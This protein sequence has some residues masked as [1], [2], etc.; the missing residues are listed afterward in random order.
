M[1]IKL[2]ILSFF[3]RFSV[4]RAFR[5]AVYIV[6]FISVGYSVPQILLFLYVCTPIG[7]YWDWSIPGTCINQ[8]AIFDA[9]NTLNM[10]TDFMILL[11]PIWMLRPMRAPLTKKIGVLLILMAGGF[12]CGVS[13]VRMITGMTGANNPDITWHYPVNLIWC[14]VEEYIGLICA[15]LPCLKAFYKRFYPNF[16]LFSLDLDQRVAASFSFSSFNIQTQ[17]NANANGSDSESNNNHNNSGGGSSATRDG[18]RKAWWS[19]RRAGLPASSAAAATGEDP[20]GTREGDASSWGAGKGGSV[21]GDG[22]GGED[23]EAAR[24]V[25]DEKT[26][27]GGGDGGG[28]L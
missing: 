22:S 9:G 3:L 17:P 10:I 5:M 6:M 27:V 8:Q 2:S 28:G 20:R 11:L 25:P 26:S 24:G 1:F 15:C 7:S 19:L 23:V 4:D 18:G 21:D 13:L 12:V 14:L 16:F